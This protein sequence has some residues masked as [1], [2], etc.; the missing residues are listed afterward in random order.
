[1][2]RAL[3][4]DMDGTLTD[5]TQAISKDMMKALINVGPHYKKYL[6]T[7]SE[8]S[9]IENQIPESFL[10]KTFEKVFACNGTRVYNT[11]LDLDDEKG[12][13]Q[14]EL[15]HKI[16]L[17]DYYSQADMNHLISYLLKVS[18][19]SHT[20]FKTGTFIEWRGSQLNFS[21]VGRN[22]SLS[23]REDYVKWDK[24]SNERR[25]IAEKLAREFQGWGLV[26]NLGG[27]IS[28]DITRKEWDKTYSLQNILEKPEDCIFFGDKIVP[29]G[30]DHS[31]AMK[32]GKYHDVESP[33]DTMIVLGQY[34][35]WR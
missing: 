32:C 9:K 5:P 2:T 26:F 3:I 4:F 10:L 18:S 12:A 15:I 34:M 35:S 7:G 33:T 30:N 1:M 6:V 22:C 21:V 16:D 23:Q 25:R 17:L 31:I 20:K 29:G 14:P 11:N 24:K 19:E 27:Q 28:I 8:M 13:P